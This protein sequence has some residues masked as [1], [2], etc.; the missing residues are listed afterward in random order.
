MTF[1]EVH[2]YNYGQADDVSGHALLLES[3]SG[4]LL[5]LQ[6]LVTVKLI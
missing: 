4:A 1:R 6:F 2:A 3:L 5:I